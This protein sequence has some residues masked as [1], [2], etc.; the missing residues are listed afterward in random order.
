MTLAVADRGGQTRMPSRRMASCRPR[1]LITVQA[2]G[3]AA[4]LPA[5]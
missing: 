5:A 3:V 2:I 4:E 1:L